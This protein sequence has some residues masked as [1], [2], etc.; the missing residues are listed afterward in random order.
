MTPDITGVFSAQNQSITSSWRPGI[1]TGNRAFELDPDDSIRAKND[2]PYVFEKPTD[3]NALAARRE[4]IANED[5]MLL[6]Q[7]RNGETRVLWRRGADIGLA[8]AE[9]QTLPGPGKRR[10][11]DALNSRF[12]C[13]VLFSLERNKNEKLAAIGAAIA[14][15][16]PIVAKV[17]PE[18]GVFYWLGFDIAT[19]IF[20]APALGAQ[21]NIASGP[22][23]L[24][25]RDSLFRDFGGDPASTEGALAHARS[26]AG[27]RGFDASV[28]LHLS[29]NYKP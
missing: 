29:R 8:A 10:I 9:G 25:I 17:R 14:H 23:S 28:K 16:D 27:Q 12:D 2:S 19:G 6:Y 11:R 24:K 21:G 20:G 5:R 18:A 15:A 7:L 22:G 4:S 1:N 3:L 26:A 13:A